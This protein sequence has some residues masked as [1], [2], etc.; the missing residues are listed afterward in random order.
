MIQYLRT[1]KIE[2][3]FNQRNIIKLKSR[4][5][6]IIEYKL[7]KGGLEKWN[8]SVKE[9]ILQKNNIKVILTINYK[10]KLKWKSYE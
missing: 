9:Y 4:E 2:W 10:L 7:K 6:K 5:N 8:G 1:G 3:I